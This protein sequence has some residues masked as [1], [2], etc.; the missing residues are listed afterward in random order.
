MQKQTALKAVAVDLLKNHKNLLPSDFTNLK[1]TL[2]NAVE[3]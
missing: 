3:S 1:K 2:D